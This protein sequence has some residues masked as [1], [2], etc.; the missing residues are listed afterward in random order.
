MYAI[1]VASLGTPFLVGCVSA[2]DAAQME[3]RNMILDIAKRKYEFMMHYEN[4]TVINS[5]GSDIIINM[6]AEDE[7]LRVK[8]ENG[9]LKN[10]I[11]KLGHT[12]KTLEGARVRERKMYQDSN[13]T[14]IEK[15]DSYRSDCN[16]YRHLLHE[17]KANIKKE[18][19]LRRDLVGKSYL[20]RMELLAWRKTEKARKQRDEKLRARVA[21]IRRKTKVKSLI[22]ATEYLST[23]SGT[24]REFGLERHRHEIAN[25]I[26]ALVEYM[27]PY[28]PSEEFLTYLWDCRTIEALKQDINAEVVLVA[29][30]ADWEKRIFAGLVGLG[31]VAME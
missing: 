8:M 14:L 10:E 28:E 27:L 16:Q 21:K 25:A 29:F 24:E 23:V 15:L 22:S 20:E 9:E 30:G 2:L 31:I 11:Q 3:R 6:V 12:I 17:A 18:Q 1:A 26:I 19:R 13:N 5:N 7:L 4:K